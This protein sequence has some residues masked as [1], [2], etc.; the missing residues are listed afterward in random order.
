MLLIKVSLQNNWE[1]LSQ[2]FQ[3]TPPIRKLIYTTNAV[4][5]FHGSSLLGGAFARLSG[6]A[7]IYSFLICNFLIT[8][9]FVNN[10]GAIFC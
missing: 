2:Y 1:E 5:G 9:H 7:Y 3:Y 6:R 4:E 8:S 10:N